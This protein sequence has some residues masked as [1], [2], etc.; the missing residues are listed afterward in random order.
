[1]NLSEVVLELSLVE[2][3]HLFVADRREVVVLILLA[4]FE[5]LH[6]IFDLAR[7]LTVRAMVRHVVSET[8]LLGAL[9]T[10][11]QLLLLEELFDFDQ[12]DGCVAA[13]LGSPP[14]SNE[15]QH[16]T[17]PVSDDGP[18]LL[19]YIRRQLSLLAH[20]L[21]ELTTHIDERLHAQQR[22]VARQVG[23]VRLT[24]EELIEVHDVDECLWVDVQAHFIHDNCNAI[25]VLVRHHVVRVT[26]CELHSETERVHKE[27]VLHADAMVKDVFHHFVNSASIDELED[28]VAEFK[29][30]LPH[31]RRYEHFTHGVP[32]HGNILDLKK[33]QDGARIS[34]KDQLII[35]RMIQCFTYSSLRC[36]SSSAR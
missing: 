28:T 24:L 20:S 30:I 22:L 34:K 10:M 25:L 14:Q 6:G 35:N 9:F 27:T 26:E 15:P 7:L 2:L 33:F 11:P 5:L 4:F 17:E 21:L 23:Q 1:M 18:A 16:D 29:R 8:S 31:R 3:Q 32:V 12:A 13:R 36:L 19:L